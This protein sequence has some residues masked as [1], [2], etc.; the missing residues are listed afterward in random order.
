MF[1][2]PI[3]S[4]KLALLLMIVRSSFYCVFIDLDRYSRK[5]VIIESIVE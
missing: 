4:E 2:K 3:I 5:S 1:F